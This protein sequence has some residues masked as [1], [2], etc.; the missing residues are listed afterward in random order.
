MRVVKLTEKQKRFADEYIISG[1][2][3]QAAIK[4]GYSKKTA[5]RIAGQNLKKLEVSEY[6]EAKLK[7]IDDKRFLNMEEALSITAAIARGEPQKFVTVEQGAEPVTNYYSASFKE[8]NQALEHFYK[9]NS[10]FD[11]K[12]ESNE[13]NQ[14][15]VIIDPWSD[16][17]GK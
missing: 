2:A 16:R 13:V 11:T 15:I 14:P 5:G 6:I 17:N 7:E 8:R 1:N 12:K 9:I 3:T 4:A 10:A